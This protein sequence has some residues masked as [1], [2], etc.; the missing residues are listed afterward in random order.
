MQLCLLPETVT[1]N[2]LTLP[3][4]TRKRSQI[5]NIVNDSAQDTEYQATQDSD[6]WELEN[7]SGEPHESSS[8]LSGEKFQAKVQKG[9]A[10]EETS[11][12]RW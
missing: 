11:E 9:W 8:L 3:L 10:Q 7:K 1:G 2:W 4:E 5:S 12:V 6:P